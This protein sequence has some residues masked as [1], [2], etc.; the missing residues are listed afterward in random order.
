MTESFARLAVVI[1]NL[2]P[3]NFFTLDMLIT[4][5]KLYVDGLFFLFTI[6]THRLL[7]GGSFKHLNGDGVRLQP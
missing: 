6:I 2:P 3:V 1:E 4:H 7:Q 5:L